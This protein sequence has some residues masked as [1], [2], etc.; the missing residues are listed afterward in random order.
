[1]T[2]GYPDADLAWNWESYNTVSSTLSNPSNS[3]AIKMSGT[4]TPDLLVESSFNY[5]GNI[6]NIVNA[7]NA[8]YGNGFVNNNLFQNGSPQWPGVNVNGPAY[9]SE[10]MG[11]GLWHNAAEDYEPKVDI[12]YTKGKHAMK[13]GFSYNRYTKNQQ[14]QADPGGDFGFNANQVG[15]A[16]IALVMGLSDGYSQ[17]EHLP[18]RHYVNQTT[19]VY[20]NDNWKV[21]P[22][23]S[24]QLGLRYDALPH[25]WERNNQTSNF[26]PSQYQALP[27]V[28]DASG[29]IDPTTPGIAT[30]PGSSIPFYLNGVEIPGQ[31]AFPHGLVTNDYNTLQPR[32]GFSYDLTGTGKTVLRG[33]IG[34]FYERLQGNDIYGTANSNTPYQYIPG[35]ANN[36]F[37]NPH[38]SWSSLIKTEY[39][40]TP[41]PAACVS[42]TTLPVLPAGL[43]SLSLKYPAP[44]VAQFSLGIQHELK[45]SLIWVLQYVGNVAWHQ[46]IDLPFDTFP[47][48]TPNAIRSASANGSLTNNGSSNAY[49]TYAGFSG[50]TEETN[51]TNGTYNGFQTGL[52]I[53]NKWG[54]S[55]ELDYTYSHEIDLTSGDLA[56]ISN[57]WNLKY[58][59]AGGS[60]D[61]RQILQANYIYKLPI[62]NKS[63]GLLHSIVGGWT[64]AGTFIDESG[65]PDAAGLSVSTDPVGLGGGYTD[66]ANVV[67]KIHYNHKVGDWFTNGVNGDS[68][69]NPLADPTP[70]Y[71]GGA[72]LG[73]G[74][75]RRDS[76]VGPGRVNFTTSLYKSFAI[77]ERAHFEFRAETFNTFNHTEFSSIGTTIGGGQYGEANGTWDPRVM[78]LATKFVF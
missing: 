36:Y 59:K 48:S 73:F 58:D 46:N 16:W 69:P 74:N 57:P 9:E 35:L 22:R 41:N 45:P 15:D 31:N 47:L 19:S 38:C 53:Q 10:Q 72:N 5:D 43:T 71:A 14:L 34:T 54:L 8:Q 76:F 55:G 66:R 44:A 64:V 26:D 24:L 37:L 7:A 1:V 4:I 42:A 56:T 49:R 62:F 17:A 50:I 23:L 28:W 33:G 61:R 11:Y 65:V 27:V 2:Q 20:V 68:G 13:F 75:G 78:E 51:S 21:N 18:I 29:A 52:R 12:S 63:S 40:T 70:G 67:T 30:A 3:A 39:D 60:Y 25:A 77:T 6:I 32:F